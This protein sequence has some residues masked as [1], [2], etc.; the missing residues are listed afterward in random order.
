MDGEVSRHAKRRKRHHG[1]GG[2]GS[3]T[4]CHDVGDGDGDGG[5]IDRAAASALPSQ[6]AHGV[7][8]AV[9][10]GKVMG[11]PDRVEATRGEKKQKKK[12]KKKDKT[13]KEEKEKEKKK[14]HKGKQKQ[15]T[16]AAV[17]G[18][19]DT[20][21]SM[22]AKKSKSNCDATTHKGLNTGGNVTVPTAGASDS[23]QNHMHERATEGIHV[24]PPTT[25]DHHDEASNGKD[26]KQKKKD[27][28]KRRH[29]NDDEEDAAAKQ[30]IPK[31]LDTQGDASSGKSR[32]TA[33]GEHTSAISNGKKTTDSNHLPPHGFVLAPMVGGSELPF[34]MLCRRYGAE[35]CYTPMM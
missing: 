3:S 9:E 15:E 30:H 1:E 7:G 31:R 32:N 5:P 21:S 22:R 2:D 25:D 34:R 35:L 10:R 16:D 33:G 18:Y 12:K 8:H 23:A 29:Q 14:G 19:D 20:E 17:T 28:K 4:S 13:D 6:D 27:K 24:K 26:K 11:D